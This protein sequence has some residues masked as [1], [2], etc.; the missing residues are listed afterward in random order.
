VCGKT[1]A[2]SDEPS[3]TACLRPI[4]P[5]FESRHCRIGLRCHHREAVSYDLDLD[6]SDSV[7]HQK[8]TRSAN[9]VVDPAIAVV[10][11]PMDG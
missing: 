3:A 1:P 8:L 9:I 10:K 7:S 2:T 4:A 5:A 11:D 6:V